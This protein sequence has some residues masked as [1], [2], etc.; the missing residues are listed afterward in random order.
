M[1]TKN[2]RGPQGDKAEIS[3]PSCSSD[4][5]LA[6]TFC[7]LFMRNTAEIRDV[8]G[9]KKLSVSETLVVD[10]DVA[11]EG[12]PVTQLEPSNHDTVRDIIMKSP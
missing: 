5:S 6:K 1:I 11:F 7:Y 12:Q 10:A 2:H 9:A 4:N 8:T 3:F